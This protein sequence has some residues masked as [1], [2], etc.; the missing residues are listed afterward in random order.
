MGAT[1]YEADAVVVGAGTA[2]MPLA[3][4]AADRGLR[5]IVVEKSKHVGGTLH[6]T[7][8]IMSAGG[9]RRQSECG[10]EDSPED[11]FEEVMEISGGEA[12]PEL[13]RRAVEEAPRTVDWLDDL[14]FPFA[15]ETPSSQTG[16]IDYETPREYWGVDDGRSILRTIRPL[17]DHHVTAGRIVPLLETECTGLIVESGE[18]RGVRAEGLEGDVEVRARSTVLTT[19]GYG[20]NPEFFAEVTP[21]SPP[22]LTNAAETSTGDGIQLAREVGARFDGAD[23]RTPSLGGVELEAGSGRTDWRKRWALVENVDLHPPHEIYVDSAGERFFA[24]DTPGVSE[25]ESAMQALPERRFWVVFDETG[26]EAPEVPILKDRPTDFVRELAEEG[27]VAWRAET[28]RELG[29]EAGIDPETL[30]ETVGTYNEAVETGED[31]LGREFLPA[32]IDDPP[33]YAVRTHD[34]TLVTFGGLD[35]SPELEVLDTD[36]DPIPNLYAAG[37]VIGATRTSGEEFAGGMLVTPALSFGR[38]L[39]RQLADVSVEAP[40]HPNA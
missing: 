6:Y 33:Y 10:I 24:E 36:G 13:V 20:A 32:P 39:G 19:G 37:E 35:A 25:R 27:E 12:D 30:V 28:V 14:G 26:L 40:G 2:G 18:V 9:T 1:E 7:G 3:I 16:H 17:W 21:G 11:H 5:V 31:P 34:T 23:N 22:L 4:T 29:R 15:P 8:G 38:I